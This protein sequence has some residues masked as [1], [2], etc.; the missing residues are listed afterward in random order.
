MSKVEEHQFAETTQDGHL[1]FFAE[2]RTITGETAPKQCGLQP[3]D[4]V[5]LLA[6]SAVMIA[7]V[8][9]KGGICSP[10]EWLIPNFHNGITTGK[11]MTSLQ[12]LTDTAVNHFT[13]TVV[14]VWQLRSAGNDSFIVDVESGSRYLVTEI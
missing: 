4:A 11:K 14:R 12:R 9:D 7:K 3:I 6:G 1:M 8:I 2:S 10:T 13:S 5:N